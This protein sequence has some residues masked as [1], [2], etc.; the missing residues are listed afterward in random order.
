M[1]WG[2]LSHPP[3]WCQPAPST[4]SM[5]CAPGATPALISAGWAVMAAVSAKGITG[6]AP[7]PRAGQIAPNRSAEVVRRSRGAAGREPRSAQTRVS[8]PGWP[9]RAFAGVAVPRTAPWSGLLLPPEL[10][11]LG[12]RACSGRRASTRAAES[13]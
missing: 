10:E 1:F 7:T 8:V 2:T 9:T 3:G 6:P 11:R 12:P 4:P 13:A 5:A